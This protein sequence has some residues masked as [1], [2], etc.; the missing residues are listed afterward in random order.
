[1]DG[2]KSLLTS[3]TFWGAALMMVA[4]ALSYFGIDFGAEDQSKLAYILAEGAGFVL[5]VW[6]RVVAK[7]AVG[8]KKSDVALSLLLAACLSLPACGLKSS[9]A[10][11]QALA[12]T[13]SCITMYQAL[14]AE[15]LNLHATL[16][17]RRVYLES[18]VAPA[19]DATKDALVALGDATALWARTQLKPA[20]WDGLQARVL[21]LL[22]DARSILARVSGRDNQ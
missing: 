9:P 1:M 6:G 5:T 7:K 8:V 17:D 11:D 13:N 20:D 2:T 10:H 22:S 14:H 16:P 15:Y 3:R 4:S 18:S 19:L 12:V 21:N